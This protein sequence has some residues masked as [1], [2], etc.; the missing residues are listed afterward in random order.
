MVK[1][2]QMK[3][4]R[5]LKPFYRQRLFYVM[6]GLLA[7]ALGLAGFSQKAATCAC[8]QADIT[9]V[10]GQEVSAS[11]AYTLNKGPLTLEDVGGVK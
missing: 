1:V 8:Q 11:Y 4:R 6:L 7:I 10:L 3:K 9:P 5:R 2:L